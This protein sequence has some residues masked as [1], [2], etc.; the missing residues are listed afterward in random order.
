MLKKSKKKTVVKKTSK[1]KRVSKAEI[2]RTIKFIADFQKLVK[3][4][5]NEALVLAKEGKRDPSFFLLILAGLQ[6]SN[7]ENALRYAEDEV[8]LASHVVITERMNQK[9]K[10]N[11]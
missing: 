1:V 5:E 7:T 6:L 3:R 10:I 4:L 9:N 8:I 2:A 11:I